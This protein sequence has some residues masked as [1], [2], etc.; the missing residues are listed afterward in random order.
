MHETD[1]TQNVSTHVSPHR[2]LTLIWVNADA[3]S[4]VFTEHGISI[5]YIEDNQLVIFDMKNISQ[6]CVV[7]R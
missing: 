4:P 2:M 1:R 5:K 3:L 7:R 6:G